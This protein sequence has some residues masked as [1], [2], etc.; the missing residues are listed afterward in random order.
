MSTLLAAVTAAGVDSPL[1]STKTEW[2]ILAPTNAAFE[3]LL[4]DLGMSAADLLADKALLVKVR[5][6]T[7]S[8]AAVTVDCLRKVMTHDPVMITG[9]GAQQARQH[10]THATMLSGKQPSHQL[11]RRCPPPAIQAC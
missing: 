3:N 2:T 8:T 1:K 9:E 10:Q 11:C 5:L 6:S 7:C 4:E